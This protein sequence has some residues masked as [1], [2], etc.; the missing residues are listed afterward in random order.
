MNF[1]EFYYKNIIKHD[2]LNKF[3]YTTVNE[4]PKFKSIV[5]NFGDNNLDIKKGT[6]ALIALKL[7]TAKTGVLT[8]TKKSNVN[9]KIRKGNPV[10]CKIILRKK[11][12]FNF[13]IKIILQVLP[14]LDQ[15]KVLNGNSISITIKNTLI[16]SELEQHYSFFKNLPNL[17]ITLTNSS[18]NFNE[19]SFLIASFKLPIIG[20]K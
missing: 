3:H 1:L 10:G 11:I 7:I 12:L 9:L 4:L 15:L 16:F 19:F 6:L 18:T 17:N 8:F 14:Y 13:L 20:K 5:L 2:L